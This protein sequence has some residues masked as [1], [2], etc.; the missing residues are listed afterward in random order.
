MRLG[1]VRVRAGTHEPTLTADTA[2][3]R[4]SD[5]VVGSCVPAFIRREYR[6][7]L[8]APDAS[9]KPNDRSAR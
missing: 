4:M 7:D 5:V 8:V 6:S 1:W 9:S 3:R 2:E